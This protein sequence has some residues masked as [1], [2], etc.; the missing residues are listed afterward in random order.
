MYNTTYTD[1]SNN[2]IDIMVGVNN[3]LGGYFASISLFMI[4]IILMISMRHNEP[5]NSFTAASA[6]VT[7][8]SALYWGMGWLAFGYIFIP[9]VMVF[10]GITWKGLD[11]G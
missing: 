5:K 3:S 10:A 11:D 2:I 7:L 8:I 1:T 6:I 4:F 9:L